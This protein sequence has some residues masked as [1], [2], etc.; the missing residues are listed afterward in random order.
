MDNAATSGRGVGLE[1]LGR[2]W[3]G[4]TQWLFG[5]RRSENGQLDANQLELQWN[6]LPNL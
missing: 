6:L 2:R 5:R 1:L 3:H 4:L